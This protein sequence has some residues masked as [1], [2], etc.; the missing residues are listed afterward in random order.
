[1]SDRLPNEA[2]CKR[3][4]ALLDDAVEP[5]FRYAERKRLVAR[6]FAEFRENQEWWDGFPEHWEEYVPA[7]LAASVVFTRPDRVGA[8]LRSSKSA[9]RDDVAALVRRW[10]ARPWVWTFFRV[11]EDLGD[12]RLRV[13][14]VGAPPSSWSDTEEWDEM[15]VYSRAT[16]ENYRRGLKLFFGLLV[17]VGPAFVTYG[18]VIP[19]QGLDE[20][21]ALFMADVVSRASASAGS[22]P[23][24]GIAHPDAPVSDIAAGDPLPFLAMLRVSETPA[25]STPQGPPGRYASFVQLPENADAWSEEAWRAAAEGAGEVLAGVTFD[26]AG[27]GIALGAG[28]PMY[29][30]AIYLDRDTGRAFVEARTRVA[31]DRGVSA[32][33]RIVAFPEEPQVAA[34]IVVVAAASGILGLDEVLLDQCGVLRARYEEGLMES[35]SPDD[36][37]GTEEEGPLPSSIEEFQAIADRLVRN[38]NE[39]TH[40]E[41]ETIA[42]ELGVDPAVVDN[43]RGKLEG[44]LSRMTER[45]GDVPE[46]D[47]FGL[48]PQAFTQLLRPGAPDVDGVL[49]LRKP[50]ELRIAQGLMAEAPYQRGVTWLLEQAL[51]DGGLG[52]TKAGYV[53]PQIVQRALEI[54]IVPSPADYVAD[55]DSGEMSERDA[56]FFERIRPKKESDWLDLLCV[57]RLA[58]SA[59][60]LRLAG[61]RFEPTDTALR[62]ADDPV[63]LYHH[64][65]ATA[66]RSF[67]WAEH[68]W[69]EAPPYLHRMAGFLFY[70][71]GEL[72][73][74]RRSDGGW[75]PV[76]LLVQRF[77]GAVPELEEA[78]R[79]EE[80]GKAGEETRPFGVSDW[81]RTTL[82]IFFV[83]YLGQRFGLLESSKQARPD[84][85]FR[86]TPLYEAVFDRG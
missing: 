49:R 29:D 24:I 82:E 23:L 43:V 51:S 57:R 48:S 17:D 79:A 61:K 60:L 16:S 7:M 86:I 58:E 64:L 39:G 70:A 18:V 12:R 8:F 77:A 62:L 44:T 28:S 69:F 42:A 33:H 21:D 78:T 56:T 47:R 52:A 15:L 67:D 32:A 74:A 9:L 4:S 85:S 14:P 81:L 31:Y 68:R 26:E 73:D 55:I 41:N 46:A 40:Q 27:G 84:A 25:V 6:P 54:R 53:S 36:Q 83:E 30:P 34:G 72:C 65:L 10:R 38:Y 66:F 2:E 50:D 63:A 13:A 1:M 5:A 35:G 75:A 37:V 45:M 76:R 20:T 59:G 11:V 71:A 19:F 22:V 3:A 80:A